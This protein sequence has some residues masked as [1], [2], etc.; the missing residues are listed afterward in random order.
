MIPGLVVEV[1]VLPKTLTGKIDRKALPDPQAASAVARQFVPPASP[2]EQIVADAWSALLPTARVGRHD[3]FFEL[4]GHSLLSMRALAA[5]QHRTGKRL[6]PRLMFFQTLEQIAALLEP[7]P[8][9]Q[10]LR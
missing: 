9:A 2:A 4:G 8:A 1:D 10:L 6:D 7:Q 3:N 5:I